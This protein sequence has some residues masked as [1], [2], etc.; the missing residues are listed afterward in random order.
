MDITLKF[1]GEHTVYE[2]YVICTIEENEFNLSY[3]PTL[4]TGSEDQRQ[5]RPFVTGSDFVPYATTIGLYNDK[6]ELVMVGKFSQP[7]PISN[8]TSMNFLLRY[9]T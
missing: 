1:R 5:V 8:E 7:M 4:C 9:D 6:N 2:N 3:N